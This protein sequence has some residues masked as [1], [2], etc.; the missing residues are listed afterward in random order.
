MG[1]INIGGG[2]SKYSHNHENI[3]VL[4]ELNEKDGNLTYKG[5]E[6][7]G[8]SDSSIL[9]TQVIETEDRKFLNK[10]EKDSLVG[11]RENIQSQIDITKIVAEERVRFRGRFNLYKDLINTIL[12]PAECDM[13]FID[14]DETQEDVS[15]I[16]YYTNNKWIRIKKDSANGAN[17]WIASNVPPTNKN[18]LWVDVSSPDPILKYYNGSTWTDI[19]GLKEVP[20]KKVIQEKDLRFVSDKSDAI[21]NK[22]E[23][24]SETGLLM[25]N[26]IVIGAGS[27]NSGANIDDSSIAIDSTF[28]SFK[29]DALLKGKQENLGFIPESTENKGKANGYAPLNENSKIDKEFINLFNFSVTDIDARDEIQSPEYGSTCYI[30]S[31]TEL[32]VYTKQNEWLL[33]SKGNSINTSKYNYNGTRN[34]VYD[35]DSSE[36]YDIGSIWINTLT[37]KAFICTNAEVGNAVWELMAGAVT[38]NIGEIIPFK[39]DPLSYTIENGKYKYEI[40]KMNLI[41]DYIELTVNGH[42][43]IKDVHYT[44]IEDETKTYILLEELLTDKDYIFGEIYKHDI[45]KA[46]EQMLKSVYDSNDNGK[47]D[48][49]EISDKSKGFISW[50]KE[51]RY[52]LGEFILKDG[53][54]YSP[55]IAHTS[56]LIFEPDKWIMLKANPF[57]LNDFT[58]NDLASTTEKTYITEEERMNVQTIPDLT[59]RV[60][61]NEK[62]I[63]I[64]ERNITLLT[65]EKNVL[66]NRLDN[67][68]FTNLKDTP[69]SLTPNAFLKVNK[70]GTNVIN[71]SDPLF[72]IKSIIDSSGVKFDNID[73]PKFSNMRMENQT[74]DGVFTFKLDATTFDLNDM[75]KKHEHGKVLVSDVNN[76]KYVLANKEEL[77]MSIENFSSTILEEEW[78]ESGNKFEATVFHNMASENLLVSFTNDLKIEDKT[79]TY[80]VLDN[81]NIKVFSPERKNIKCVINCALGAGNGYWQYLMDWSKID[82]VDDSRI[83]DD[84]AYSSY[85]LTN[86]L[87]SYALKNDYYTKTISDSKYAV[88]TLEHDHLNKLVLDDFNT[89]E[90]GD[91]TF[92]N[93]RLLT[94]MNP[95]TISLEDLFD[96]AELTEVYD[97][98]TIY[99]QN[100][101]QAVIASE[102][103]V[104]NTGQDEATF[105]IKD[106]RFTLVTITLQPNEV[107]K[108]HLGISNKVKVFT[109]GKMM[110]MLTVSAF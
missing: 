62:N 85:K 28:S 73:T 25:Y 109:K 9:A 91:V 22:M 55:V 46:E 70:D 19:S 68:K 20:A 77:T 82:F 72:P 103:L 39:L 54:L 80:Q 75:P 11:I 29:I 23:E 53:A 79:I 87:K 44:I 105:Q 18:L 17:G 13:A 69:N 41:T 81:K 5:K 71:V 63:G 96:N 110:T 104:Q 34:P 26:G 86:M 106:G 45:K 6:I 107:Q 27:N 40:P 38:L 42:E 56:G 24:D 48:L 78:I 49:A 97:M 30:E 76:N 88:K 61:Q 12:D 33:V 32:F 60:F 65:N 10:K 16:Y 66:K 7:F 37:K 99:T 90:N 15:T 52:E 50:T 51:T 36:G 59:N 102:I 100:N 84:R 98:K 95:L 43:A 47:V 83:R 2:N 92:K 4:K 1:A 57:D 58:T 14:N 8:G 21:L 67:L 64:N 108:Y 31:T 3:E 89:D 94:E 35:D 74:E 101:L 93:K